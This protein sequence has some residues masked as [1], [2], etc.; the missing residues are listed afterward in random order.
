MAVT[1][2]L[3]KPVPCSLEVF[4]A[5]KEL[6]ALVVHS[7]ERGICAVPVPGLSDT[8]RPA[9]KT[10]CSGW[11]CSHGNSQRH[12]QKAA[13]RRDGSTKAAR[14]QALVFCTGLQGFSSS[15]LCPVQVTLLLYDPWIVGGPQGM[16]STRLAVAPHA[17]NVVVYRNGDPFFQGRKLVVNQRQF[18]TFE[19]FLNE[20]TSTIHAPMAV[21]NIYT[22][23]QGH[24]VTELGE[25]QNGCQYVAAGFERFKR[26]DYLNRGLKQLS[27]TRKKNG[28]QVRPVAPQK[29]TVSARW[30]KPAHLPCVIHVFRNGDLL[31]PPFRLLLSK[32]TLLE[33]D[34]VLGLL[35]EK[36][37]LLSGAVR[38]LCRLDGVAVSS[39]EEL[40]NGGYYV[41]VGTEKYK[42]LPYFE[43]LVPENSAQRL[44]WSHPNNRR[45]IHNEGFSKFHAT[46]Q[47]G[48]S[49]SALLEPPQQP[50]SRRVQSTGAAEKDETPVPSLMVCRP[51][52]RYPHREEESV[53]HTK[54]TC[55]GQNKKSHRNTPHWLDQE[56]GGVYKVKDPRKE[57]R[58]AQEVAEDEHTMVELPV[59]QSAAET[60]EEEVIPKTRPT[61]HMKA[62]TTR[63]SQ[64]ALTTR[65]DSSNSEAEA[66]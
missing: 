6:S 57:M 23:R 20:V 36:A 11:A 24:R 34:A 30:Q 49:D 27:G 61:P 56:E 58:G 51:A 16:S 41:A 10:L 15:V 44:F 39:G 66:N 4:Q 55:A 22:P 32:S 40:V 50:D 14:Q 13:L 12:F 53:F 25:L 54:P 38:R 52:R 64:K 47:D 3:G 18:L 59:D 31:S 65:N 33:W 9:H 63:R 60:V 26:L 43:L 8:A 48:A 45:G 1:A 46:S 37:S 5:V 19:A 29:L 2:L 7:Q 62:G 21:R 42:N 17:K 28:M 35:T